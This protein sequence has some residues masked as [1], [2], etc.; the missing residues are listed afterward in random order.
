MF[1]VPPPSPLPAPLP[2]PL[3][4]SSSSSCP[5]CCPELDLSLPLSPGPKS[6]PTH[7]DLKPHLH[8]E[9][10][11]SN[12]THSKPRLHPRKKHRQV[13]FEEP[14][15]VTVTAEPSKLPSNDLLLQES[16]RRRGHRHGS[17]HGQKAGPPV[18]VTNKD[19]GCVDVALLEGAE[20]N[21]SL[22]LKAELESLQG[23][24]FNS[25]K[26]IEE[27]LRRSVRTT[28]L[29]NTKAT[30]GVNVSLS[31]LL[32]SSLVSVTVEEDQLI[33]QA[34]R[35]RLLLAPPPHSHD[36]KPA[37]SPSRF[38]FLTS[39][40]LR[41]EPLLLEEEPNKPHPGPAPCPT[42]STFD[43]YRRHTRWQATP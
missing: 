11:Q 38:H 39:N 8:R 41:E 19:P 23:V 35:D 34:L 30:E 13:H 33:S 37:E 16:I 18:A 25:Q 40:L 15:V 22:A 31:Q 2:A 9:F 36:N 4:L 3:P 32:Y 1:N 6:N 20:L 42:H 27:T 12:P 24:E 7:P 26:A 14:V 5:P 28:N 10:Q 43:L 21:S 17:A 29:I